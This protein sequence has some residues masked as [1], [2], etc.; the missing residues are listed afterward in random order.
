MP[1]KKSK[2]NGQGSVYPRRNKDGK[3]I[4]YLGA[5]YGPDAKRRYVS[6]KSKSECERKLRAAMVDA[7]NGLV[8]DAGKITVGQ[9]LWNYLGFVDG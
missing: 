6:A 4:G 1:R 7:D 3:I 2:G 5:Y 9:Y 8:F